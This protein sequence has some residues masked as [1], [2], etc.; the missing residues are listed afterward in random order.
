MCHRFS[1]LF[2]K[3]YEICPN[4]TAYYLA[5]CTRRFLLRSP[6][7][8]VPSSDRRFLEAS[9]PSSAQVARP[10]RRRRELPSLQALGHWPRRRARANQTAPFVRSH[11][12]RLPLPWPSFGPGLLPQDTATQCAASTLAGAATGT[13]AFCHLVLGSQPNRLYLDALPP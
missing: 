10:Q 3:I 2:S 5:T 8:P 7:A 13:I 9:I 11:R 12:P 1:S 4:E 6:R